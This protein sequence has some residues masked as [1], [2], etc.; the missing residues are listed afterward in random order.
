MLKFFFRIGLLLGTF[1]NIIVG[2][3]HVIRDELKGYKQQRIPE[4]RF[5]NKGDIEFLS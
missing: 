3:K 4:I 2:T 1:R 5:D